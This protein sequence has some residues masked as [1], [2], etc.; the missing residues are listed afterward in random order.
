MAIWYPEVV[1]IPREYPQKRIM[2]KYQ[3]SPKLYWIEWGQFFH[4]KCPSFSWPP[5]YAAPY[6]LLLY[7]PMTPYL[8]FG[9]HRHA[10]GSTKVDIQ[11]GDIGF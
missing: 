5:S 9:V 3:P 2:K 6:V 1:H 7:D 8:F 4:L 10:I 11:F